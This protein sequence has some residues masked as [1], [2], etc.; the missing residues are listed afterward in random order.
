MTVL[1]AWGA[2]SVGVV[3]GAMWRSVCENQSKDIPEIGDGIGNVIRLS[4][5]LDRRQYQHS[6]LEDRRRHA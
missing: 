3:I 4:A 2:L 5:E 6:G 1:I